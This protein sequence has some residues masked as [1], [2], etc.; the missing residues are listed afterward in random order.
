GNGE[1]GHGVDLLFAHDAH[2]LRAELVGVID[3]DDTGLDRVESSGL[4]GAM[5]AHALAH[6]RRLLDGGFEL[7]LGVLVGCGEFA[8]GHAV[9]AGLINL[10]KVRALFELLPYHGDQFAGI[11]GVGGIGGDVLG[12]IEV[13]CVF[14][15]S[16]NA[17]GVAAD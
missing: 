13:D 8:I 2:G 1:G 14:V 17:D 7:G 6:A 10:D 11:V 3:G 4:A 12:G 9:G 15:S 5:D 16:E